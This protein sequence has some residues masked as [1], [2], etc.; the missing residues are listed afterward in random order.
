MYRASKSVFSNNVVTPTHTLFS[1]FSD[2]AN[3]LAILVRSQP[4]TELDN[5]MAQL[6][7]GDFQHLIDNF[8]L[9]SFNKLAVQMNTLKTSMNPMYVRLLNYMNACLTTLLIVEGSNKEQAVIKNEIVKLRADNEV[10]YNVELLK[11][12]LETLTKKTFTIF[13]DQKVA[14]SRIKLRPEYDVYIDRYGFPN[15][16]AFN[17]ALLAD[18]IVELNAKAGQSIV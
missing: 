18:I 1:G 13:P 2:Q 17:P 3:N 4:F 10:L 12:Y 14:T 5:F 7:M 6:S 16:G 11:K 15:K 8:D 9:E